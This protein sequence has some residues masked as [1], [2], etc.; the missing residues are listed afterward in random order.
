MTKELADAKNLQAFQD[1]VAEF[2]K[3]YGVGKFG[4]HKAFRIERAENRMQ[5]FQLQRLLMWSW[6]I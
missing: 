3:E 4:L 6:M 2:Y 1:A 5:I